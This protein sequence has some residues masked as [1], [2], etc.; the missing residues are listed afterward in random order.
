MNAWLNRC[1]FNLDSNRESVSE[2]QI[3]KAI[4]EFGSQI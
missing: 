3:G 1:V 2:P 4:A